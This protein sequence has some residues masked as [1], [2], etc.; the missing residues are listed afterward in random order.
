MDS[1]LFH[2][3]AAS[4]GIGVGKIFLLEKEELIIVKKEIKKEDLKKEVLRFEK[5]LNNTKK[6]MA[7]NKEEMLKLLGKTHARLA[8]AYLLIL[9][10]PILTTDIEK[11]ILKER[12]N[13]EFA[14]ERALEK[15]MHAFETMEDDYF[16]ERMN[17][18][19]EVSQKI[20]RHLLGKK[21]K[22]LAEMTEESIVVAHNLLP[23]DTI[24]LKTDLIKGFAI[25]VGGKTSHTALLAQSLEIP[26][27]VGLKEITSNV[28]AGQKMI[29]DGNQGIVIIEPNPIAIK[30]YRRE[31]E[32]QNK[33]IQELIKLRDLPAQTLDGKRIELSSNIETA[34]DIKNVLYYGSEGIGLFR[35]EYLFLNRS[36]LPSEEEQYE[37]YARV[38]KQMMPYQTLFR[39]LDIGGDKLTSFIDGY[40][41]ESN[42]F[43]GLR[44]LRFCLK[45]PEIFKTQLRAILRAS[46]EG[47]VRVMFPMVSGLDEF[48]KGKAIL[49]SVKEELIKEKKLMNPKIEV[50]VMI[51]VP[52]AAIIADLLAQK[53]DFLSIGTNDLIQ[54]TLAVDRVN[55]NVASLYDPR[56]LS[57]LRLI[58]TIVDAAHMYGKWVGICGEMASDIH[59][60]KLLLGLGLDE[61][62]VVPAF[63]PRLKKIIR[64]TDLKE[65]KKLVD[66][67]MTSATRNLL[68]EALD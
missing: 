1:K 24:A 9:E 31:K 54:Y 66:E 51:E 59:F 19:V 41:Q 26:A 14:I 47:N 34:D 60:T 22:G 49:E 18:I 27:V 43:L 63:I 29:V 45:Y 64:S 55:E 25:D 3:I 33:E 35:T 68:E 28:E 20:I 65:A 8:D 12:I 42:P 56:H 37:H 36:D 5:A 15:V 11:Q 21:R 2:G 4:P 38:A 50:G 48:M 53:A 67:E 61:F 10:D 40:A 7:E 30:N 39:T 6:E 16:R 46:K 52:S 32:I 17:D 58:K 23:S 44:A 13:A 62:S 57:I